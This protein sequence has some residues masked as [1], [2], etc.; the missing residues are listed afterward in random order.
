[1]P[2]GTNIDN[3]LICTHYKC[4]TSNQCFG[5]RSCVFVLLYRNFCGWES[6]C[7]AGRQRRRI[8]YRHGE[9]VPVPISLPAEE[10]KNSLRC[11]REYIVWLFIFRLFH[12]LCNCNCASNCSANHRVITHANKSHHFNVCRNR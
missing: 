4:M 5:L 3:P 2:Y 11:W 8:V 10:T 9:G 7:V 12:S 6:G 1:M